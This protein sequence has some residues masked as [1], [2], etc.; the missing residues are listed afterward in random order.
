[1]NITWE[2]ILLLLLSGLLFGI[3]GT[4]VGIGGGPFYVSFLTIFLLLPINVSIDTSNFIILIASGTG[5]FMYLKDHRTD[6]KISL[7]FS[8]LSILGSLFSTIIL[9]FVEID[10]T[11]LRILFATLLLIIGLNMTHKS[12]KM[13]L[14]SENSNNN[15]V[16]TF[17][18]SFFKNLDYKS[19]LKKGA[20]LFLLAGF[21]SNLLGIGGGIINC[22]SL[23]VVFKFPIHYSTAVSTS[24]V[25]F[26]AIYNSIAKFFFG[27]IDFLI[28]IL[29]G[30]GSIAGAI[31][32]VKVSNKMSKIYLQLILAIILM[33]FAIIM[34]F[35]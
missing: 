3:I 12:I 32:G 1:M 10:N 9:I 16:N 7:I 29:L 20:P 23:N 2:L 25:F 31:I 14:D 15:L 35:P 4:V 24:V 28:G 17:D 27:Q 5:F 21:T 22:P 26:T 6:L 30:V 19:N 11:I 34:F 8:G 33:G 13:H 18:K